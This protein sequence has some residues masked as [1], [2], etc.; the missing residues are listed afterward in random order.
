MNKKDSE[1]LSAFLDGELTEPEAVEALIRQNGC[2]QAFAALCE[3]RDA[4]HG[5][6]S[7]DLPV[8]FSEQV[9]AAINNEPTVFS[10]AAGRTDAPVERQGAVVQGW[11]AA[12]TA[13][14]AI[15]ASVAAL[16]FVG[17]VMFS[18]GSRDDAALMAQSPGSTAAV[19]LMAPVVDAPSLS[20]RQEAVRPV[21]SDLRSIDLNSLSPQLR[22]QLI[23][24]MESQLRSQQSRAQPSSTGYQPSH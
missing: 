12:K 5:Q 2:K 24:H 21:T 18:G 7:Q 20:V 1:S 13:N 23:Q 11:F 10:P 15:A 4:L 16:G 22:Y 8:H 9:A 19:A 17:L 3:Q 6:I 14:V